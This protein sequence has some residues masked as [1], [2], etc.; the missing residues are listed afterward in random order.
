MSRW[1]CLCYVTRRHPRCSALPSELFTLSLPSPFDLPFTIAGHRLP[2]VMRTNSL[3]IVKLAVVIRSVRFVCN[4]QW[5]SKFHT[6]FLL[7]QQLCPSSYTIA[8]LRD[9]YVVDKS[10][11]HHPQLPS[12][13]RRFWAVSS[14]TCLHLGLFLALIINNVTW[15]QEDWVTGPEVWFF[16]L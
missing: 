4:R 9:S 3:S 2:G 12:H 13:C 6:Q 11:R 15:T 1:C 8:V 16:I 5:D 10:Q 14:T 7:F